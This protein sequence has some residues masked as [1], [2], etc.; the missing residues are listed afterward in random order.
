LIQVEKAKSKH[1]NVTEISLIAPTEQLAQ[2]TLNIIEQRNEDI[3]V[4]VPMSK[5]DV[6]H[7]AIRIA[8]NLVD[9]GAKVLISRKGTA[10]QSSA[11]KR[12]KK[13]RFNNKDTC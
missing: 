4:F 2:R 6:L 11:G 1:N 13:I 8:K 9:E 3:N 10:A 12:N 5:V 7:D